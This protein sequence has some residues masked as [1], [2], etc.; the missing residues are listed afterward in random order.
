MIKASIKLHALGVSSME[1]AE[2]ELNRQARQWF[3]FQLECR[4][5]DY[6]II[7]LSINPDTDVRT[8]GGQPVRTTWDVEALAGTIDV[9][10][11]EGHLS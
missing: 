8:A 11:R 2:T 9:L 4:P 6:E 5:Q 10:K 7:I 1:D 3:G